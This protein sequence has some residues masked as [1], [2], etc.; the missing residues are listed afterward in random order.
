MLRRR[1]IGSPTAIVIAAVAAGLVL[2]PALFAVAPLVYATP[3]SIAAKIHGVTPQIPTDNT[4]PQST[5]SGAVCHGLGAAHNGKFNTFRCAATADSG[6]AT[7]WARALPNGQF[8]ASSTGLA[9]CPPWPL[10]SGDPRICSNPP[11]PPT[12]DPNRCALASSELALIRAGKITFG[13]PTWTIRN[14]SCKGSNLSYVCQYS[15]ESAYGVYYK[16]DVTFKHTTTAWTAQIT[17]TTEG[18]T[19]GGNTCTVS[20]PSTPAGKSSRW[21]AGP[22]PVCTSS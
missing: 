12:A 15:S 19:G 16:S 8:C 2:A 13:S 17:T 3:A 21:S 22:V 6:P 10:L 4:S 1:R 20:P 11:S 18:H 7:I 14:L 5:I 9:S